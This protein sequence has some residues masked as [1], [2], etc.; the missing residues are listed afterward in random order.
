MKQI[1]LLS[2]RRSKHPADIL[3]LDFQPP[4]PGRNKLLLFKPPSSWCFVMAAPGN[5]YTRKLN[6]GAA[7]R[8]HHTCVPE[9]PSP[10]TTQRG[11]T[12]AVLITPPAAVQHLRA[13]AGVLC[14]C[15]CAEPSQQRWLSH[16]TGCCTTASEMLPGALAT[17][18]LSSCT[19][20]L[21]ASPSA[22]LM[23][24]LGSCCQ[25]LSL[26]QQPLLIVPG[27]LRSPTTTQRSADSEFTWLHSPT[28]SATRA[29]C[30]W[31]GPSPLCHRGWAFHGCSSICEMA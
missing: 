31:V 8:H 3:I 27:S 5:R 16:Q 6:Y 29:F 20:R 17:A 28:P 19:S 14:R 2:L 18:S 11:L 25:G 26:A 22:V 9:L 10:W 13:A 15:V 24:R 23:P 7:D 4:E 1:F 21:P 12:T 30:A